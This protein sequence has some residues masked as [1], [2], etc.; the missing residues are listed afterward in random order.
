MDNIDNKIVGKKEVITDMISLNQVQKISATLNGKELQNGDSLPHLWQWCFCNIGFKK[1]LLGKDGHLKLGAFLPDFGATN[2]MWAG[3]RINFL[4]SLIIGEKVTKI[5]TIKKIQPKN[6]KSG[7][8]IFVTLLHEYLQNETVKL[9]EEQDIVYKE[10]RLPKAKSSLKIK[11]SLYS[12]RINVN[13]IDLFRYSA[14]TFNGHRIHYDFKYATIDE[15]Y[16]NLVVHGPLLATYMLSSFIEKNADKHILSFDYKGIFAICLG[17]IFSA[18][19]SIIDK[20]TASVWIN[21]DG[22]IAHQAVIKFKNKI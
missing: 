21:N 13:E 19:G 7:K 15:G 6:G 14:L 20:N 18:E 10:P 11:D 2:R 5:T 3:G 9:I 12:V 8:L 17:D 22:F 16:T 4:D 1:E